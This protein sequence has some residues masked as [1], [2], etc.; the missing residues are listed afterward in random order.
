ASIYSEKSAAYHF[1][2]NDQAG[3]LAKARSVFNDCADQMS[4]DG[5]IEALVDTAI[6]ILMAEYDLEISN[7]KDT[8]TNAVAVLLASGADDPCTYGREGDKLFMIETPVGD[9]IETLM[10]D[11]ESPVSKM[12]AEAVV[13]K[14]KSINTVRN[15]LSADRLLNSAIAVCKANDDLH[16]NALINSDAVA[17]LIEGMDVNTALGVFENLDTIT[18]LPEEQ[19]LAILTAAGNALFT[20]K[21]DAHPAEDKAAERIVAELGNT[22]EA[23]K[24]RRDL[25]MQAYLAFN[26]GMTNEQN[27][28]CEKAVDMTFITGS[29]EQKIDTAYATF[30]DGAAEGYS[31][32]CRRAENTFK[33]ALGDMTGAVTEE[34]KIEIAQFIIDNKENTSAKTKHAATHTLAS[35]ASGGG[36]KAEAALNLL[37]ECVTQT[38]DTTLRAVA[39]GSIAEYAGAFADNAELITSANEAL[40]DISA[41]DNVNV[42]ADIIMAVFENTPVFMLEEKQNTLVLL[43]TAKDEFTE[44]I[45]EAKTDELKAEA[46][47]EIAEAVMTSHTITKTPDNEL[48]T[49]IVAETAGF[50]VSVG[51]DEA[52]GMLNTAM[53]EGQCATGQALAV[54]LVVFENRGSLPENL[55]SSAILVMSRDIKGCR[56][57]FA[58]IDAGDI[59]TALEVFDRAASIQKTVTLENGKET[60]SKSVMLTKAADTLTKAMNEGTDEEKLAMVISIMTEVNVYDLEDHKG[61]ANTV[62]DTATALVGSGA[63]SFENISVILGKFNDIPADDGNKATL[64]TALADNAFGAGSVLDP[65]QRTEVLTALSGV[66]AGLTSST[67]L[68]VSTINALGA[69]MSNWTEGVKG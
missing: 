5:Q 49:S 67:K 21:D 35:I 27:R 40:A 53:M 44:L 4:S 69:Y 2:K 65:D 48:L 42:R 38:E 19:A 46:V 24:D 58:A 25:M 50:L 33:E 11:K 32:D 68:K 55:A 9:M 23:N 1:E 41:I 54:A 10:D 43:E 51:T 56:A 22:G 15:T 7:D 36:E 26:G 57:L 29:M 31:Y 62:I 52:I 45:S 20:D 30:A 39:A 60:P 34:T 64:I 6:N 14:A 28:G 47:L 18:A 16:A 3:L 61:L 8:I 63:A 66:I 13:S 12:V 17:S 59:K 37:T